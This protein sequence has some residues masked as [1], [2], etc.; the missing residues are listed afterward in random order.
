MEGLMSNLAKALR[1]MAT[2][3]GV[4][5]ILYS[6]GLVVLGMEDV[7]GPKVAIPVAVGLTG[8]GILAIWLGQGKRK[9]E[10]A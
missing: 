7:G 10:A 6:L 8:L 3:L 2:V 4:L 5:L 9:N 1:V